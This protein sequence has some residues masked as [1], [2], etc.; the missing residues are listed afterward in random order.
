M[1]DNEIVAYLKSGGTAN[2]GINGRNIDVVNLIAGLE[3]KGMVE[4]RDASTSQETR[5]EVS[6]IGANNDQA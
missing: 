5:R 1:T 3:S 6:W 4:T 2:Y